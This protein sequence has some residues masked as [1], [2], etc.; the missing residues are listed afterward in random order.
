VFGICHVLWVWRW[1]G[2]SL[3]A[4]GK[5]ERSD[6]VSDAELRDVEGMIF[7]FVEWYIPLDF[8]SEWRKTED[9]A[10]IGLGLV[11]VPRSLLFHFLGKFAKRMAFAADTWM[12]RLGIMIPF[13]SRNCLRG[14][15]ASEWFHVVTLKLIQL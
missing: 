15:V 8:A 1:Y 4:V 3:F 6:L 2:K 10:W 11:R 13:G 9:L 12:S 14:I 5:S 7:F